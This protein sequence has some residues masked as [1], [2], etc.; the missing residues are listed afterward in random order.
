MRRGQKWKQSVKE[1]VKGCSK[2]NKERY[3]MM[4]VGR[5]EIGKENEIDK[6][7]PQRNV[8]KTKKNT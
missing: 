2:G 7:Q 1:L 4:V 5:G 3:Q 6:E 8:I